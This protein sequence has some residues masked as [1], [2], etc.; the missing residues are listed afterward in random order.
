MEVEGMIIS[1]KP[2]YSSTESD[3]EKTQMQI[4][5]LLRDY[6]V[7]GVQW[8][9]RYDT[10]EVRLAFVVETEINGVKKKVGIEV[11]PPVF[12]AIRR[13]WDPK[14]GKYIK[15]NAPNWAQS[16]RLLYW[17][18]KA[19]LEAVSYGLSTVEKEFLAQV[20][21]QLPTGQKTTV[22][23]ALT[24]SIAKGTLML[25]AEPEKSKVIDIEE[26]KEEE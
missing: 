18:L 3:P 12:L 9:T 14:Q 5:K 24:N 26:E 22:G 10:N 8:T 4:N 20:M 15:V 25:G 11:T 16:F 6:G 23:E 7:E 21:V 19:K 2:P 13:T 1:R 17:W